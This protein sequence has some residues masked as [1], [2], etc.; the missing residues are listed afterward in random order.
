MTFTSQEN[1][2]WSTETKDWLN[3]ENSKGGGGVCVL[4]I[5]LRCVNI[6]RCYFILP[7]ARIDFIKKILPET[8]TNGI[9]DSMEYWFVANVNQSGF[10]RI[11]YDNTTYFQLVNQLD[12][13]ASVSRGG[14]S[15]ENDFINRCLV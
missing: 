14:S 11:K 10:F 1:P 5:Q 2:N 8:I 15:Y 3:R 13:N 7:G 4:D 9:P 6:L 12:A